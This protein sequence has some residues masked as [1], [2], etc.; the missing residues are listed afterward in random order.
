MKP[1][2][3]LVAELRRFE[4]QATP[5]GWENGLRQLLDAA[6]QNERLRALL[7]RLPICLGAS[8][9]ATRPGGWRAP[10]SRRS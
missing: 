5:G 2:R 3:E 6:E 4:K 9:S 7:G 1:L 10:A 8:Q